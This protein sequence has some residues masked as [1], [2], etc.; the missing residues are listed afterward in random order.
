VLELELIFSYGAPVATS[1]ERRL[2][3]VRERRGWKTLERP[4][5]NSIGATPCSLCTLK[6]SSLLG[7][8][9]GRYKHREGMEPD[10]YAGFPAKAGFN[11]CPSF[12]ED[13]RGVD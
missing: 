6:Y 9:G 11:L 1:K 2:N 10:P 7:G 4:G 5:E 3:E 12:G 8:Q 13:S